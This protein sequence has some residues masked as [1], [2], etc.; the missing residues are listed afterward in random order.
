MGMPPR[1]GSG[2]EG[3]F[4]FETYVLVQNP[5]NVPVDITLTFQT[6]RGEVPGPTD[7]IAG[8][9]H[10]TYTVNAYVPDTY[11]VSTKVTSAGGYIICEQAMYWRPFPG[12]LDY[13]GTDSIGYSP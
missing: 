2:A 13:L 12:A 10:K 8:E 4:G 11:D 6:E 5:N 7:T 9:S 1:K 3:A